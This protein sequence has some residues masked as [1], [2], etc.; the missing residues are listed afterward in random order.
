MDHPLP[1]ELKAADFF[2]D[3]R[4][5]KAKSL[6]LEALADKQKEISSIQPALP[7]LKIPYEQLIQA[8]GNLRGTPLFYPYIGSGIGRGPLVELMD[9]SIKYD[10][11]SGIGVHFLGH[12]NADIVASSID[13]AISNT[14]MQGP[15]QQNI[16]SLELIKLL[17]EAS[18]FDCCFLTTSGAMANE[19]A[20]KLAFH[21][22]YPASRILAFDHSFSGR[23]L[24][25]AQVTDKPA[26]RKGLPKTVDVDYIPFYDY[27]LGD[28]SIERAANALRMY[29]KRYPKQH[30]A[31]IFELIQGEGGFYPGTKLFFTTLM[32]ILKESNIVIIADEVQTF[33]RTS[34]L[35]C[36]QHFE[37]DR[38]VDI[39]TIGKLSHSCA[40][41]F[42][43]GLIPE[44][45]LLSQT[46]SS[47]TVSIKASSVIIKSLLEGEYFGEQGKNMLLERHFHNKLQALSSRWPDLIRGPFGMG[48][49]VA[50]TPYDGTY[51]KTFDLAKRLFDK[52]VICFI[53]GENPTRI[54]FLL[55]AGAITTE[56]IDVVSDIIEKALVEGK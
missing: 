8:F 25:L 4:V 45:G 15:L 34:K 19:N 28:E 3:E 48:A 1:K 6:L 29:L 40:T 24:A 23:T 5:K 22:S 7:E 39:A 36:F 10:F 51:E 33:G 54:R 43:K 35:F 38:F 50:F 56:D 13:S 46:F 17:T 26:Y 11:I 55:P 53:A 21:K 47:S 32:E 9:G 42:R 14:V 20:L 49:M 18:S 37:L 41:L 2:N 12:S 31:M 27:R 16:D 52:G 44:K 30:A